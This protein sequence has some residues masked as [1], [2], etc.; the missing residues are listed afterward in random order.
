MGSVLGAY[1]LYVS[2]RHLSLMADSM[3]W[4]GQI[5]AMTRKSM[6][7][8]TSP[9]LRISYEMAN[10]FFIDSCL[11]K[12]IDNISSA[13]SA[14]VLGQVGQFGTNSFDIKMDVEALMAM[15]KQNIKEEEENYYSDDDD[16]ESDY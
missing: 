4:S 13:S 14:I 5:R 12:D 2:Y 7:A 15:Q 1:G 3:T 8:S 16:D 9:F 10:K 11:N 6:R